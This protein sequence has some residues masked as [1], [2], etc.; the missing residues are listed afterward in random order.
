[1]L[2]RS[3]FI[4]RKRNEN[5]GFLVSEKRISRMDNPINSGNANGS[6]SFK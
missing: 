6:M 5:A 1:M 4:Q 3:P 2:T